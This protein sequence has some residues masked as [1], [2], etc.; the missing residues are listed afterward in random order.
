MTDFERVSKSASV[1]TMTQE[2]GKAANRVK[3]LEAENA[4]LREQLEMSC[5]EP[6]PD[7]QCAGCLL[8]AQR[9]LERVALWEAINAVVYASGGKDTTSVA[10]Q[11]AV[12]LVEQA[13]DELIR[14]ALE[15]AEKTD[16]G[17]D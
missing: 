6:D 9:A 2:Y 5:I 4:R 1:P 12:V 17:R 14:S 13:V 3:E 16:D 15:K 7:C 11:K 8:A 10:R